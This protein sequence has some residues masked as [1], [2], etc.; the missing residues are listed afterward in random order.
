MMTFHV[1]YKNGGT[2]I[3]A[4]NVPN[5]GIMQSLMRQFRYDPAVERVLVEVV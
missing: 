2:F 5:E 3:H 1:K 4:Y